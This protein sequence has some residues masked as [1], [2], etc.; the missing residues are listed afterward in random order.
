LSYTEGQSDEVKSEYLNATFIGGAEKEIKRM[1][2]T[3]TPIKVMLTNT[4]NAP[5]SLNAISY[6]GD[7]PKNALQL[8][9]PKEVASRFKSYKYKPS[10][11]SDAH[12]LY[13]RHIKVALAQH[14]LNSEG[15]C[16]SLDKRTLQEI[17][18]GNNGDYLNLGNS[19]FLR[20]NVVAS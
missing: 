12:E 16:V 6:P 20:D 17:T 15:L 9:N 10:F 4:A 3:K 19:N 11:G 1:S 2:A 8:F 14:V 13:I 18:T 5:I 7:V